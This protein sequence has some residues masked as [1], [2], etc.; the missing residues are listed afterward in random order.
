MTLERAF[1]SCG[2]VANLPSRFAQRRI[3]RQQLG[4]RCIC[5]RPIG[6]HFD[7]ASDELVSCRDVRLAGASFQ[8]VLRHL[9]AL[10]PPP[11]PTQPAASPAAHAAREGGQ[12][13]IGAGA[14]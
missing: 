6:D 12:F 2:R 4:G 10:D 1:E 13:A 8:A 7:R 14:R 5:G 9:V 11:Q 3:A